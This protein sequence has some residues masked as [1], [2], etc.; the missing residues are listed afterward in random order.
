MKRAAPVLEE[1]PEPVDEEVDGE[2]RGED[3]GEGEVE[4]VKGIEPALGGVGFGAV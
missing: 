1:G 3:D 2:L 4:P